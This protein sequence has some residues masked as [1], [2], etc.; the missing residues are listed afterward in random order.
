MNQSKA[1]VLSNLP[2]AV[3]LWIVDGME[4]TCVFH[5]AMALSI[6]PLPL[7]WEGSL[8]SVLASLNAEHLVDQIFEACLGIANATGRDEIRDLNYLG[9]DRYCQLV[10]SSGGKGLIFIWSEV[11]AVSDRIADLVGTKKL[12]AEKLERDALTGLY[13]RITFDRELTRA[14]SL[15]R[16]GIPSTLV[17]FDVDS[18]KL[19]NDTYGHPAGDMAL[20]HIAEAIFRAVREADLRARLSGDEF[21]VLLFQQNAV[22][23]KQVVDRLKA[24]IE[25]S[26]FFGEDE[27]KITCSFGIAEVDSVDPQVV[28]KRA[29]EALYS[30]KRSSSCIQY[31]SNTSAI[32]LHE[33][34]QLAIANK[35]IEAWFQPIIDLRFPAITGWEVLSRWRTSSGEILF[36]SDWMGLAEEAG[37]MAQITEQVLEQ[38]IDALPFL[39]G[40]FAINLGPSVLASPATISDLLRYA[41]KRQVPTD[42]LQF[43][44]LETADTRGSSLLES[45]YQVFRAGYSLGVDDFGTGYSSLARVLEF[46][47]FPIKIKFDRSLVQGMLRDIRFTQA[48]RA[49]AFLFK[50]WGLPCVAE[51]IE[52]EEAELLIQKLIK[53]GV[54]YGQGWH[55]TKAMPLNEASRWKLITGTKRSD[56]GRS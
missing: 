4:T 8:K 22:Q 40:W 54:L 15:S 16:R 2:S 41:Q 42:R 31:W 18:F 33:R 53:C 39:S 34:L 1:Y 47:N 29:D 51:G 28:Y 7:G 27:I 5:N 26:F 44:I 6:V 48:I 38:A 50:Q 17:V 9:L 35:E 19:V 25:Q 52:G 3:T 36:P 14:V 23:A 24:A 46:S 20:Q 45:I 12:L 10:R 13:N 37:L 43:E 56:V 55:W 30:A 21:A 11:G 32:S 49:S